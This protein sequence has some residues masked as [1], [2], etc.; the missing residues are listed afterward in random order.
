MRMS[1]VAAAALALW[2][3]GGQE[4]LFNMVPMEFADTAVREHSDLVRAS[5]SSAKGR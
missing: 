2:G 3:V 4:G 5:C 1:F